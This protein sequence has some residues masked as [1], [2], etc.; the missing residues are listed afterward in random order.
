MQSNIASRVKAFYL[1]TKLRDLSYQNSITICLLYEIL[2]EA[3]ESNDA[4]M[5]KINYIEIF[6]LMMKL[7]HWLVRFEKSVEC[8]HFL[9]L[10]RSTIKKEINICTTRRYSHSMSKIYEKI[11]LELDEVIQRCLDN[12]KHF[13]TSK[14][15]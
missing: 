12:L 4:I 3:K 8:E 11:D 1:A 13:F 9:L 10:D 7:H 6:S 15:G 5:N 14:L 2:S